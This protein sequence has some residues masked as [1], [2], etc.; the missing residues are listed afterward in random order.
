[1]N[2]CPYNVFYHIRKTM[3]Q[4]D[5]THKNRVLQF[6]QYIAMLQKF[7]IKNNLQ[8]LASVR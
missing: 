2:V 6:C 4:S 5:W 1:M 7:T 8:D 3:A